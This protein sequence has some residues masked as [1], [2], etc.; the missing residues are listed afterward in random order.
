MKIILLSAAYVVGVGELFLSYYFWK[1]RSGNEVRKVMSL[2]AFFL[3]AWVLLSVASAYQVISNWVII[4]NKLIYVFGVLLLT[5]LLHLVF[6]FPYRVFY[7]DRLHIFLLYIPSLIFSSLSLFSDSIV[8]S[9]TGGP[10]IP[11]VVIGG[12]VHIFYNIYC[13]IIYF[14]VVA[15]LYFRVRNTG[16]PQKRIL[17]LLFLGI[18]I[19]GFPGILVDVIGPI[20]GFNSWNFLYGTILTGFWVGIV[21]WIVFRKA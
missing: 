16:D 8:R 21:G 7:F 6:I 4:D 10:S 11:G 5:S 3:S 17:K 14:S 2:F 12:S 20:L 13:L 15:F 1:T 19:G 9:V 18:T